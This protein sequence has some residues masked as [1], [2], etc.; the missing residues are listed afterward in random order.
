MLGDNEISLTLMTYSECPN[1]PKHIDVIHHHIRELLENEELAIKWIS[2]LNM[3]VN[4]LTKALLA[5]FFKRHQ[6][7]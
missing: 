3:L 1:R 2:R 7:E 5:G 6:E 4:G